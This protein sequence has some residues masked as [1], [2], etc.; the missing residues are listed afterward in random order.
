KGI[1]RWGTGVVFGGLAMLGAFAGGQLTALLPGIVVMTIFASVMIASGIGMVRGRKPSPPD[2]PTRTKGK[3]T[4]SSA[5][6]AATLP[7]TRANQRKNVLAAL[8]SGVLSGL[9]GPGGGLLG[10]AAPA[11]IVGITMK[12]PI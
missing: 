9:V 2:A 7:L 11:L 6:T 12:A 1:V 8:G 10:V 4:P 5:G 3:S